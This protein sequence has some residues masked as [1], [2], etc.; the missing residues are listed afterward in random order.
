MSFGGPGPPATA[1]WRP[2]IAGGMGGAGELYSSGAIVSR[3]RATGGDGDRRSGG[4]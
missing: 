3:A 1:A 4:V 2:N